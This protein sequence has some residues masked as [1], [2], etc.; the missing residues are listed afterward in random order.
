M[1]KILYIVGNGSLHDDAELRWSLR[2]LDKFSVL[3]VE[4]VVVGRVPE[5]FLGDSLPFPDETNRKEKNILSKILGAVSSGLVS[6][7]FQISADDH[8]WVKP[9]DLSSLPVY[10][11]QAILPVYEQGNNYA[12]ALDGTRRLLLEL[13]Y[14]AMNTTVHCNQW[15]SSDDVGEVVDIVS[16]AGDVPYAAEYGVV[17]WAVWPNVGITKRRRPLRFRHDIKLGCV[18]K[19]ELERAARSSEVISVNNDA[20]D[21]LA[22]IRFMTETFPR[23]SRWEK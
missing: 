17:N 12:K 9:V 23:K 1:L 15:V 11:R 6:G 5:W 10:W 14:P 7:D 21:S 2:S 20:F 18:T 4:P 16:H 22:F 13:G 8:F 3:P 19:D